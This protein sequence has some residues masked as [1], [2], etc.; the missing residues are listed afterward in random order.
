MYRERE[1]S[2]EGLAGAFAGYEVRGLRDEEI[3]EVTDLFVDENDQ[4]EYIGVRR[5]PLTP[6]STLIPRA[7]GGEW[8]RRGAERHGGR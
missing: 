6:K 2:F 8:G 5:N 3:G 7:G 1:D 4:L